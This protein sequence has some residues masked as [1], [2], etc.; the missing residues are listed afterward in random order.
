MAYIEDTFSVI[1]SF[2]NPLELIKAR[3]IS[4]HH[5]LWT[6]RFL[7]QHY[8]TTDIY[9]Y[10]C[11]MC[12]NLFD[13][14]DDNL[15]TRKQ[16]YGHVQTHPESLEEY[17]GFETSYTENENIIRYQTIDNLFKYKE[18]ERKKILC[19]N[20]YQ[21]GFETDHC[22]N[23]SYALEVNRHKRLRKTFRY[24]GDREY[25]LYIVPSRYISWAILFYEQDRKVYWNEMRALIPPLDCNVYD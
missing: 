7:L 12:G 1:C 23:S 6:K 5:N 25:F 10:L 19:E 8:G 4:H 11:P 9:N 17:V 2:L 15:I 16:L 20:C 18:Y 14:Y 21:E 3:Y 13:T 24:K 22:F